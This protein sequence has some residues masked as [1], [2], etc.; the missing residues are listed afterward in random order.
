M[1]AQART[2]H[3]YY[4]DPQGTVLAKTDVQG[5]ILARYDY[6][7]YG[8]LVSG[9]GP[10]GPGYTGHVND[11]ETGL[12][13]MQARHYDPVGR[14]LSEDPVGPEPGNIFSFNRYAYANNNPVR[15]TDPTGRC[16]EYYSKKQG[17]GCKVN[18]QSGLKGKALAAAKK[19]QKSLEGAL[20]RYDKKINALSGN[21][22]VKIV[23]SQGKV[24]GSMTGS[25]IKAVWNG[26]KFTVTSNMNYRNGGAGGG[27]GGIWNGSS[28]SGHS[29]LNAS[30]V[31]QYA[32]AAGWYKQSPLAGVSTLVFHE[33]GH[34]THFGMG[35]TQKYP[36]TSTIEWPREW[37][38]SSAGNAMAGS[39]GASF[40]CSIPGGCMP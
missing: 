12:V 17:G 11:L 10:D 21:A 29:G 34:E 5:N 6:K 2:M 28:F 14:F 1:A 4:T 8:G 13:Y 9:Q 23:N 32:T 16:A 35:L 3:F 22:N 15:F 31:S 18:I 33:L 7:P 40:N 39:V 37:G 27:T 26:T 30:A 36:V 20:N 38:A 25:E 19:A 24:I